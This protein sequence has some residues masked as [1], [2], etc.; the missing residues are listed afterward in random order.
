MILEDKLAMPTYSLSHITEHYN[1]AANPPLLD[2]VVFT[3]DHFHQGGP[4][5]YSTLDVGE[6]FN[7]T[8]NSRDSISAMHRPG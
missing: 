3:I 8:A 1:H 7:G 4:G 2:R 6:V 5:L